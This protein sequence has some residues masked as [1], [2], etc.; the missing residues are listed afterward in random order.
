M[1]RRAP[2]GA[3]APPPA[4]GR[5]GPRLRF[6][7]GGRSHGWCRIRCPPA[8]SREHVARLRRGPWARRQKAGPVRRPAAVGMIRT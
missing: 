8:R 4:A 5:R 7:A 6:P 1:R 3:P 2:P